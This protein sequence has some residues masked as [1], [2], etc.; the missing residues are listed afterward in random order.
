MNSVI[1]T[2][3]I[4]LLSGFILR[5]IISKNK[6]DRRSLTGLQQFSSYWKAVLITITEWLFGLAAFLLIAGGVLL[7]L[8]E[9]F[10]HRQ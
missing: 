6:F 5:V 1:I 10:N 9:W 8:V 3:I 4:M 7:L 2:G